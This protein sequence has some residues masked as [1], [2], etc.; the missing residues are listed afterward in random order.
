MSISAN[1]P[2]PMRDVVRRMTGGEVVFVQGA[3]GNVLPR[4]AFTD[5]ER[6]AEQMGYR[7]GIEALHSLSGRHAYR[8]RMTWR[9]ERS[10]MQI[11][12]YRREVVD[13]GPVALRAT[14]RRVRFPLLPLPSLE[15]VRSVREEWEA[16]L[17]EAI[18]DGAGTGGA[19]RIAWWHLAWAAAGPSRRCS[20]APRRR[21]AR[22]ASTRS[23][24][25][26][27]WSSPGRAR[28]SA[29]SGWP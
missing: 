20:T 22:A 1:F 26:T 14:M 28:C 17:A 4:V 24:S 21:S 15:E 18:A 7:L 27:G 2:G 3:G 5:S 6:E 19:A 29:R 16:K 25:E 9:P 8:R 10:I 12:S 13:D 11:S 23:A